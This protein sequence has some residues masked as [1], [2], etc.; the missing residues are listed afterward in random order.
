M[1][2]VR[3]KKCYT[4][5]HQKSLWRWA[6]SGLV[7]SGMLREPYY[8]MRLK[9]Y[10]NRYK[11]FKDALVCSVNCA[12]RTRCQDFA[13]F[14]DQRRIEIDALVENYYA[15]RQAAEA[16]QSIDVKTAKP[17]R[18]ARV[19][20][21][22]SRPVPRLSAATVADL[23]SL[24]RLEVKRIMPE[25]TYIWIGKDDQA[26]VLEHEEVIR[27]AERGAKP[28]SIFRVAQ[29][30]E[31][32]FQL[33]P[34]RGIEKAK[35]AAA[36]AAEAEAGRAAAR[37]SRPRL[38]TQDAETPIAGDSTATPLPATAAPVRRSRAPRLAKAVG[39]K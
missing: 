29:E 28:K 27:R 31:L 6:V 5:V 34:R 35:R 2:R 33:V 39:E 19:L 25:I 20:D 7:V 30:M 38:I 17:T 36:V 11:H 3:N 4:A 37:R 24:V 22:S 26:E 15:T 1:L 23:S 9:L 32:R 18:A 16:T 14:Y 21:E 13:L 8:Q 10:C 12:Y